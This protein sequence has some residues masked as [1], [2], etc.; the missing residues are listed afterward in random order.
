M[1]VKNQQ[2][3]KQEVGPLEGEP[4]AH[5]KFGTGLPF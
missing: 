4:S 1:S 3:T 5:R 2:L